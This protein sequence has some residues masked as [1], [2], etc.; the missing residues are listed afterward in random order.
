[1]EI[2]KEQ[3]FEK[4]IQNGLVVVDFFANWCGPCRMMAPILEEAQKKLGD[5]VK[6][7]K[8]DVDESENLAKKFGIM[9]IPTLLFFVDGQLKDKHIGLMMKDEFIEICEKYKK[10]YFQ[11]VFSLL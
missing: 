4:T 9:S 7:V 1:M 2:I 8:V 10:I 3:D 6:I 11:F 5:S